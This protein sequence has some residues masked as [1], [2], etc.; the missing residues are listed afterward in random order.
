MKELGVYRLEFSRWT[1]ECHRTAIIRKVFRIVTSQDTKGYY[2]MTT[3]HINKSIVLATKWPTLC[4]PEWW[5]EW[6]FRAQA[7]SVPFFQLGTLK[8]P[9]TSILNSSISSEG[10]GKPQFL[11]NTTQRKLRA[12]HNFLLAASNWNTPLD[13]KHAC[14]PIL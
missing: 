8:E 2:G 5:H 9:I 7:L 11:S 12:Y 13:P 3:E 14:F 10:A 4:A 1:R 6:P